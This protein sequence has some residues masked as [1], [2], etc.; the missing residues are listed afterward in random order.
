MYSNHS[1]ICALIFVFT[2]YKN[3]GNHDETIHISIKLN[4]FNH[5]II[6]SGYIHVC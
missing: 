4:Y 1:S 6:F 5:K 2:E 3:V